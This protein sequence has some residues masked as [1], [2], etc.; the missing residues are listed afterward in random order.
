[1]LH[2]SVFNFFSGFLINNQNIYTLV[3][4]ANWLSVQPCFW[5]IH[6]KTAKFWDIPHYTVISIIIISM[7]IPI[8]LLLLWEDFCIVESIGPDL[9]FF[10]LFVLV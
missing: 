1:M 2:F 8:L 7:N 3:N 10:P 4:I 5:F 9:Y 6:Q